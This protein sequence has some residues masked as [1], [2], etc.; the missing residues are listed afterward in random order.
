MKKSIIITLIGVVIL[1]V[2]SITIKTSLLLNKACELVD[3][4]YGNQIAIQKAYS[5]FQPSAKILLLSVGLHKKRYENLCGALQDSS[6]WWKMNVWKKVTIKEDRVELEKSLEEIKKECSLLVASQ[7]V[8]Q[9]FCDSA[10]Y[11][12]EAMMGTFPILSPVEWV[13][14]LRSTSSTKI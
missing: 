14:R 13:K 4:G 10:I 1:T 7:E 2:C 11:N 9:N 12:S 5:E 6:V 3:E 8:S